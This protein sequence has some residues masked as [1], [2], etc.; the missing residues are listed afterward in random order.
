MVSQGVVCAPLM[1]QTSGA[2]PDPVTPDRDQPA[3][4]YRL[5]D[6]LTVPLPYRVFLVLLLAVG[7]APFQYVLYRWELSP[8]TLLSASMIGVASVLVAALLQ[9]LPAPRPTARGA[10]RVLAEW[11][12]IAAAAGLGLLIPG[13]L[14]DLLPSDPAEWGVTFFRMSYRFVVP[15]LAVVLSFGLLTLAQRQLGLAS[16]ALELEEERRA[17]LLAESRRVDR[18]IAETLHRTVQGRLAAAVIMLRLGQREDAWTQI[19]DMAR[20]EIPVLQG[21]L[22]DAS[23]SQSLVDEPPVG[24]HV[25]Q[26]GEIDAEAEALED[27]RSAVSEIAVNARRHGRASLLVVTVTLE[28]DRQIITCQDNGRGIQASV[29]AGLGS[30]LLDDT[31]ALLGGTWRIESPEEGC[32]VVIDLPTVSRAPAAASSS[33]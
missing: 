31:V 28:G 9:R 17:G 19:V 22:A 20:T 1:G 2:Q 27:L 10:M 8:Q 11:A 5:R 26:I 14:F 4:R 13:T 21:R 18:D 6:L 33:A 23:L 29:T 3:S 32:R 7:A 15:G 16:A 25:V 24:L 12:T 30:R